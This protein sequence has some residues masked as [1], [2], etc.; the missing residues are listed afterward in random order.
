MPCLW[1]IGHSCLWLW[2]ASPARRSLERRI[3][4]S[5]ENVVGARI[6]QLTIDLHVG[7]K[8]EIIKTW[9][10]SV[11]NSHPA[12]IIC[13]MRGDSRLPNVCGNQHIPWADLRGR[14]FS[15]WSVRVI[16]WWWIFVLSSFLSPKTPGPVLSSQFSLP[17][18]YWFLR[19]RGLKYLAEYIFLIKIIC[20]SSIN[21]WRAPNLSL[22][23]CHF[24][25]SKVRLGVLFKL[26]SLLTIQRLGYSVYSNNEP[27]PLRIVLR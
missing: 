8:L 3:P 1:R 9:K 14:D 11:V 19:T 4:R 20:A 7:I 21:C 22:C 2:T 15:L 6:I 18:K 16:F 26:N 5:L 25:I 23:P 12:I 13:S 24:Y 17:D 27:N 10:E